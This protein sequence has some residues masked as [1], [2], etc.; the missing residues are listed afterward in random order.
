MHSG[1]RKSNTTKVLLLFFI[2][3]RVSLDKEEWYLFEVNFFVLPYTVDR[4]CMPNGEM[5]ETI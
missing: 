4:V 2:Y 5:K 3:E 1:K